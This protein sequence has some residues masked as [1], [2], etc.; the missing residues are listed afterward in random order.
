[1]SDPTTEWDVTASI[2]G[3]TPST[4]ARF[5]D[6][7][8]GDGK[9][10]ATGIHY[11]TDDD[12]SNYYRTLVAAGSLPEASWT[13]TVWSG[14]YGTDVAAYV[15]SLAFG[16]GLWAAVVNTG[17]AEYRIHT[18]DDPTGTWTERATLNSSA[19]PWAGGGGAGFEWRASLACDGTHWAAQVNGA[20]FTTDDPTGSWNAGRDF[21]QT[22]RNTY[23]GSTNYPGEFRL[24]FLDGDWVMFLTIYPVTT[25]PSAQY[26]FKI[27]T[28]SDPSGTWTERSSASYDYGVSPYIALFKSH[29][30]YVLSTVTAVFLA[31]SLDGPWV[32]KADWI[33]EFPD[34]FDYRLRVAYGDGYYVLTG[35]DGYYGRPILG[36]TTSLDSPFDFVE[37][38]D[39]DNPST[40]PARELTSAAVWNG[41]DWAVAGEILEGTLSA[42][43]W[44]PGG[45]GTGWGLLL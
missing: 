21:W 7:V 27:F 4:G 16:N 28:A 1:M 9:F 12:P 44:A 45:G 41:T 25:S 30:G 34:S 5:Y 19:G 29:E 18:A 8:Y 39:R 15:R 3:P 36:V 13:S 10:V 33:A 11:G 37:P 23:G 35:S 6:L 20:V 2:T 22:E 31:D 26:G 43:I 32:R 24:F 17:L 40:S 14:S 42:A 38:A